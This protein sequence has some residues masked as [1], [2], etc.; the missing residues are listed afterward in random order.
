MATDFHMVHLVH[1][2]QQSIDQAEIISKGLYPGHRQTIG[3]MEAYCST[4]E[5][6]LRL[7]LSLSPPTNA[8]S[9]G[10]VIYI[11]NSVT[12]SAGKMM[13]I[14]SRVLKCDADA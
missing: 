7:E 2:T 13:Q 6:K 12:I 11:N 1:R 5:S 3:M 4:V 10:K 14:G 9:S 8:G